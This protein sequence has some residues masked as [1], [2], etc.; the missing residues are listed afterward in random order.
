MLVVSSRVTQARW[1]FIDLRQ[2]LTHLLEDMGLGTMSFMMKR[3]YQRFKN[4]LLPTDTPADR[5]IAQLSRE[6]R[7]LVGIAFVINLYGS[8]RHMVASRR[9]SSIAQRSA[10]P[11]HPISRPPTKTGFGVAGR[12]GVLSSSVHCP[13]AAPPAQPVN[14]PQGLLVATW[15]GFTAF[16]DQYEAETQHSAVPLPAMPGACWLWCGGLGHERQD[17]GGSH[18]KS[19]PMPATSHSKSNLMPATS[20]SKSQKQASN[21]SQGATGPE[22]NRNNPQV[23]L[24]LQLMGPCDPSLI[25]RMAE[26]LATIRHI[27]GIMKSQALR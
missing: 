5:K 26:L 8:W 25:P 2:E 1:L 11:I 14:P 21:V 16:M 24:K 7:A 10:P 22:H 15:E 12:R 3:A 9:I 4:P 18:C 20:G 17:K 13:A 27:R 6:Q 19:N 23:P